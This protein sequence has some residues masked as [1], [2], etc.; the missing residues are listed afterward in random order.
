MEGCCLGTRSHV[1]GTWLEAQNISEIIS[2]ESNSP[3]FGFLLLT[4]AS[5][6]NQA[7]F[8][9]AAVAQRIKCRPELQV[10]FL[11]RTY[12]R[13]GPQLGVL[14]RQPMEISLPLFLSPFS[15]NKSIRK[16]S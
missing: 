6:Q 3:E 12:A 13:P 5:S 9:L 4:Y 14:E 2:F 15:E 7:S 8:T 16:V 11:V 10:R 1:A